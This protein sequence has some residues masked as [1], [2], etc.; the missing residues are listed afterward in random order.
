[1]DDSSVDYRIIRSFKDLPGIEE[2]LVVDLETTSL[3]THSK[4]NRILGIGLCWAEG[5]AYYLDLHDKPPEE[6]AEELEAVGEAIVCNPNVRKI[7]HNIKFDARVFHAK[8]HRMKSIWWDTQSANYCLLTD[9]IIPGGCKIS[10]HSL[11]DCVLYWLNHVKI[12]T[13]SLI[14][15]KGRNNPNPSLADADQSKVAFYC[16]EDVDFTYR[17]FKAQRRA[18]QREELQYAWNLF[19]DIDGP[20]VQVVTDMECNGLAIDREFF[21]EYREELVYRKSEIVDQLSTIAGEEIPPTLPRD[22]VER[23]LYDVLQI[24]Q[25]AG[26]KIETTATGARKVT[27]GVIESLVDHHEWPRKYLQAKKIDKVLSTYIK[28]FLSLGNTV[29]GLL[30][31]DFRLTDTASGRLSASY[32]QNI[33]NRTELGRKLR[34]GIVSKF[35]GGRI[36][37]ADWSQVEIRLLAHL[38]GEE[39]FL[40]IFRKNGDPHRAVAAKLYGKKPEEV[41]DSERSEAKS[42][43]FGIIYRMGPRKLAAETGMSFEEAQEFINQYESSLPKVRECLNNTLAS[44]REKGYTETMFGRRRY[45]PEV[46]SSEGWI[47]AASERAGWNHTI[48]GTCG[49]IMKICMIE[50]AKRLDK[51]QLILQVHDELVLDVPPEEN[52]GAVKDTLIDVM[53]GTVTLDVPLAVDCND[54]LNW[55]DA[56]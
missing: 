15:K 16:M 26:I 13:K 29:D 23:I 30:H 32:F 45:L 53:S 49:D 5:K 2:E 17:L 8:G 10:G 22:V 51:A 39:F 12:R 48:Q 52:L 56:H 46:R 50:Q 38:S 31:P 27:A 33:P 14:P 35:P 40:D 36:V 47:R 28:P 1:M 25:K 6:V 20:L 7:G 44:L 21:E 18:F 41:T 11:D 19:R 3:E 42:I 24:P 4:E 55:K 54:A 43:N 9:Q 37:D 34:G